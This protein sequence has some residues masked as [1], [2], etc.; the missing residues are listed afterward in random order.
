MQMEAPDKVV[1]M[2]DADDNAHPTQ[3]PGTSN[4]TT[5]SPPVPPTPPISDTQ[6]RSLSVR[7][8]QT[9]LLLQNLIGRRIKEAE[10]CDNADVDM[11]GT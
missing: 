5:G 2:C 9:L 10:D 3:L 4:S 7:E 1:A 11:Q 8:K 6:D